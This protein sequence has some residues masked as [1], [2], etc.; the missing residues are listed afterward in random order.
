M[1]IGFDL[2]ETWAKNPENGYHG[3]NKKPKMIFGQKNPWSYRPKTGMHIQLNSGSNTGRVPPGHT[4][5]FTCVRLKMPKMV[6]Q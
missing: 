3:Y 5:S 4:S 2:N 6:F 1:T